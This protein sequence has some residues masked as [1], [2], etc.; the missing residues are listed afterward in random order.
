MLRF[1][2]FF[3]TGMLH[4][5]DVISQCRMAYLI[6]VQGVLF[7]LYDKWNDPWIRRHQ[8]IHLIATRLRRCMTWCRVVEYKDG[9]CRIFDED[10]KQIGG[11]F[12]G[13][14]ST[15]PIYSIIRAERCRAIERVLIKSVQEEVAPGSKMIVD[16][17]IE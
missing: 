10:R 14:K 11:V 7:V 5:A 1:L 9:S 17:T 15:S 4:V 8:E 3:L 16:N 12:L 2:F 6:V 13:S